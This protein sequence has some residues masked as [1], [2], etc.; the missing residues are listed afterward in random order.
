MRTV[1]TG[2]AGQAGF[3]LLEIVIAVTI[4]GSIAL[5]MA[6]V[7]SN[8]Q[9][10]AHDAIAKMTVSQVRSGASQC[11]R[12]Y[13]YK[14]AKLT[15]DNQ[16]VECTDATLSVDSGLI[17]AHIPENVIVSLSTQESLSNP[18]SIEI[19][20]LGA[21]HRAGS[22]PSSGGRTTFC[23]ENDES[24]STSSTGSTSSLDIETNCPDTLTLQ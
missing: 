20:Q 21:F 18:G 12:L 5:F 2:K 4:M 24:I 17:V 6:R 15:S 3:S 9:S 22:I 23:Q 13:N 14:G 10:V 16:A 19:N 8:Q 11:W 1:M 7:G